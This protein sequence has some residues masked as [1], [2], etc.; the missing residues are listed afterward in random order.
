MKLS[1][2]LFLYLIAFSFT[3]AQ[4]DT[5]ITFSE[6]MF[7][8]SASNSEFIELYNTSET[9][10]IDLANFKVKY[11]T[12][13]ADLIIDNGDGTLLGPNQFAVIFEGDYDFVNGI[14][15]GLI[16]P[17]ALVLVIDNNAF[18][19]SGMANTS[20][21]D[22]QLLNATDFVIDTYIYTASGHSAG[23]SD[24]KII[25][26][27]DNSPA[28]WANSI[29]IEGTPGGVNS[30]SP[31]TDD[32]LVKS[33]NFTPAVPIEGD[34]LDIAAKILNS[35]TDPAPNYQVEIYHD[36]N[37]NQIPDGG[38]QIELENL[39]NLPSGDSVIVDAQI[40]DVDEGVY[41]FIAIVNYPGDQNNLN[42]TLI[43]QVNVAPKPNDPFDIVVNEIMYAPVTGEP[44]WIELFN[45]SMEPVNLKNWS[46]GD[47]SSFALLT[48]TDLIVQP[49][50]FLVISDDPNITD[51]Y[52]V[53]SP[54]IVVSLPAYNN[55]G[56]QVRLIDSL[57]RTI[58]S[59]EYLPSWGGSTGNSLERIDVDGAS[60]LESNWGESVDPAGATP[61]K[62]N[63]L[64]PKDFDLKIQRIV[65]TPTIPFNDDDVDIITD[66]LNNGLQDASGFSIEIFNDANF[67]NIGQPGESIFQQ[68][69]AVNLVP[70]DSITAQSQIQNV[71]VGNYQII[72]EV[73]YAV[74]QDTANNKMIHQFNVVPRPNDPFD[75]VINEVM[76][77]PTND[78]PEWVELFNRS[79]EDI[80]LK[81]WKLG[82]NSNFATIT[83]S[84]LILPADSF[85]VIARD[86]S[87]N[88]FYTISS[89]LVIA[90]LPAFNN[91]G[92]QV[93]VRDS[94]SRTI[95]SLAY[96]PTWGGTGG[97]SLERVDVEEETNLQSNWGS[98]QDPLG[99]TPG[100]ENSITPKDF[101]LAVKRINHSPQ[102]PIEG[103]PVNISSD[104]LNIGLLTAANFNIQ[105]FNDLNFD[106]IGQPGESIFNQAFNNLQPGDSVN[107]S[108]N[109][110]GLTIG[111][112]Q[113]ISQVTYGSDENPVNNIMLHQFNVIPKPN[114]FNDI[115]VNEV[116]YAPT[117]DEPEWIELFNRTNEAINLKG[118]RLGDNS[119]NALI[120]STNITIPPLSFIV[121]SNDASVSNFYEVPS[122]VK[123][124]SLPAFN[125]T[126][127]DVKLTDSLGRTIDSLR[128][129][130]SWGGSSGGRSLERIDTDT[131][132]NIQSNWGSSIGTTKAT[133]GKINSIS[134]KNF[135]LA[136]TSFT[137][138]PSNPFAGEQ[139]R[140]TMI[141]QN[142]GLNNASNYSVVLYNDLNFDN[143]PQTN[144]QVFS[145][146]FSN[147]SSGSQNTVN[148]SLNNLNEGNYKFIAAVNFNQD[149]FEGNN[150]ISVDF[151]VAPP[152]SAYND[153]IINEFM[154]KPPTDQP[155]WVEIYNQ[156]NQPINLKNWTLRDRNSGIRI[157]SNDLML[158]GNS[159]LVISS[160]ISI[161]NF[162]VIPSNVVVVNIP[163]LNN[164]GDDVVIRD[165]YGRRI[166][167][168]AY[169]PDWGGNN[170]TSLERIRMDGT[171]TFS[172]NWES[173]L[174][175][176]GAT[177]GK[178]NSVI[179]KDF[180]LSVESVELDPASAMLG[181][182]VVIK[183]EIFNKGEL[184][185][186][187]ASVNY[188]IDLNDDGQLTQNELIGSQN[189]SNLSSGATTIVE[190]TFQPVSSGGY[191]IF[192]EVIFAQDE[193]PENNIDSEFL[194]V[195]PEPIERGVVVINEI[196]FA[197]VGGEP[198]WIEV[199]NRT[200][201][202]YN[203]SGWRVRDLSSGGTINSSLVINPGE[204]A[205]IAD[206]SSIADFYDMDV[207]WTVINLP[208]LNNDG[209]ELLLTDSFGTVVDSVAYTPDWGKNN[210]G[211]SLERL[212]PDVD[213]N[214]PENWGFS[215]E[216]ITGTPGLQNSIV[217]KAF[218]L[219]AE[220]I[221]ISKSYSTL[222]DQ[223]E[224]VVEVFNG[225]TAE[226]I[227]AVL[228][229]YQ[230]LRDGEEPPQL[231]ETRDLNP[232]GSQSLVEETFNTISQSA[233][234]NIYTA[235]IV[236]EED[237]FLQNNTISIE[238]NV[239]ELNVFRNDI[240]INEIMY[241]PQ[242][243]EPE[244]IEVYNRSAS[245][246]N[247]DKFQI[248]DARDTNMILTQSVELPAGSFFVFAKDSSIFEKYVIT[249]PVAIVNIPNLNN[250]GDNVVLLDSL[251][252]VI[253][254]VSY[255]PVWG[256]GSGTSLERIDIDGSSID[257]E[258]WGSSIA[259]LGATPGSINSITKKDYDIAA[260]DLLSSPEFPVLGANV[261]F[262]AE[263]KNAGRLAVNQL[264]V[265][266]FRIDPISLAEELK[267]ELRNITLNA[268]ETKQLSFNYIEENLQQEWIFKLAVV[269]NEDENPQNN[270]YQKSIA[271]SLNRSAILINELMMKPM[272]GEPEWVEV[273]NNSDRPINIKDWSIGDLLATPSSSVITNDDI[274]INPGELFVITKDSSI[275]QFHSVIPSG[276]V[277][278]NIPNLNNDVDGVTLY[279]QNG[280]VIDSLRYSTMWEIVSG[281]SIERK[282]L[283][284]AS[285]DSTNWLPS[286]DLEQ[287]TP[288]RANSILQKLYDVSV[289]SVSSVPE[290]PSKGNNVSVTAVIKNIGL[291]DAEN[292]I[293]KF[294]YKSNGEEIELSSHSI[295][296][297][298][299]DSSVLL[300]SSSF[301]IEEA[302]EVAAL[303]IYDEDLETGNNIKTK[304]ITPGFAS[305][306][307]LITEVMFNP[308][309]NRAEWVEIYNNS[310]ETVNLFDWKVGDILPSPTRRAIINQIMIEPGA[311]IVITEDSSEFSGMEID[312]IELNFGSL[313][314]TGDGFAVYDFRNAVIDSMIYFSDWGNIRGF[315]LERV[316]YEQSSL[317][318]VNWMNSIS[319]SGSTPGKANSTASL[320]TYE[321]NDL[322]INEI[323]NNTNIVPEFI[324]FY[325]RSD[326]FIDVG[327]WQLSD[328]GNPVRLSNY[329]I[330]IQPGDY[331]IFTTD[332]SIFNFYPWI[333]ENNYLFISDVSYSLNNDSELILIKDVFGNVVDSVLYNSNWNNRNLVSTK[334]K[335]LERINPNIDGNDPANWST[336]AGEY[337]AT[338]GQQNS[339]FIGGDAGGKKLSVEPNPFSPDGDGFEDNTII[340][341]N[342]NSGV[343]QVRVKVFDSKGRL[344]RTLLSNA[345][346]GAQGSIIFDGMKDD[347]SALKIG[348]YVL[349]I[350]A[351][352]VDS[353]ILETMKAAVV[354]AR[355]L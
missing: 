151:S 248:A 192:A 317:D 153:V 179:P 307:L 303:V 120:S 270:S 57:A 109:L 67:D 84:D 112:Y 171:S 299:V 353:G 313:G 105:L 250:A 26:N 130:S 27:R 181:S 56:D 238:H 344:V 346:S 140:F 31:L 223:I 328:G 98:S 280:K 92:D 45:R 319:P 35:G 193:R 286:N 215:L 290:F 221:S 326:K 285:T 33:I 158:A 88:N 160:D 163:A 183:A 338:P 170:G 74:D 64:T 301:V 7:F 95:D 93:R 60:T 226:A 69:Y 71:Q 209:D 210:P 4:T 190:Q 266:L 229:I 295:D 332:S 202:P 89:R 164:T 294:S 113:I 40:L 22:L 203:L 342:L 80:N 282:S 87:I 121:I 352:G 180:D 114:D 195:L 128:Y 291:A 323:M 316:S 284:E 214:D 13:A 144:E 63:S 184:S 333:D 14:Y 108:T 106:G 126:G 341:Y 256:G 218:D 91:T 36:I 322:V 47:N 177:P 188:Y 340:T 5:L 339:L 145:Q 139:V 49:D 334:D 21:R 197:P 309:S 217:P 107:I 320:K 348:I 46:L 32:L 199:Y 29:Q 73:T 246:I 349:L 324:E 305:S 51:F 245:T 148:H 81:N 225:G 213:S 12:A 72:T 274:Y 347:G 125:N 111:S 278:T 267:E 65:Q 276:F 272:N 207:L 247:L 129:A 43:A 355:R 172:T 146:S 16:D 329:S 187:G 185:A 224:I 271:P 186:N 293:V 191:N 2:T 133:P 66:V 216:G 331:F 296:S 132:T 327:G 167:S 102:F 198:E 70:G 244:W 116:M 82:D 273:I 321:K 287:S 253:D 252:R 350:E 41:Q 1:K 281:F 275:T 196:M 205:V 143:I 297:I 283:T 142:V 85:L 234:I 289:Q 228:N 242:A 315:S 118:W 236:F 15:A 314:N 259:Q 25:M 257:K 302:A 103:E 94:L 53:E 335:S 194:N 277:E 19:S 38:E 306:T 149:E 96:L 166:D 59:L 219:K 201:Q 77:A 264:S 251:Y 268:D 6:I 115:V 182:S 343:S 239:V 168:L 311:Y 42:D 37:Q 231:V 86:I 55:T 173:S 117:S 138:Q 97:I 258:N 230:N 304:V 44:E 169:S 310:N 127:D 330:N 141:V 336:S 122:Q 165:Q 99:G 58:D 189:V 100:K 123:V 308:A 8:P 34:D 249:S 222:G 83:N 30:V 255:L 104:I 147:L 206:D 262:T 23:I 10:T 24:E 298:P 150:R 241:T 3:Y 11:S 76:Y 318:S 263:I 325:N 269:L 176:S 79:G 175:P 233:G 204:Y 18:G 208:S 237:E 178:L 162:Y 154:Y 136:L 134:P 124:V 345:A 90:N 20:D 61:G 174:D 159:Y 337:G 243:P 300:T 110:N 200:T 68:T 9:E 39:T 135:D 152:P 312:V 351:M 155:E 240:V 48:D 292:I 254:S 161:N 157:S 260:I 50:S 54:I 235:E 17:N 232:I 156:T 227:N 101:D 119:S 288:G 131:P 212:D 220:S 62:V 75:I 265:Q 211:S 52:N 279:D 78:E 354:V 261:S 137:Q 28:N